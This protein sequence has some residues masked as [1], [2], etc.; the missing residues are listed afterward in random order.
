VVA[1]PVGR[2][3][4]TVA[5]CY[6]TADRVVTVF[7]L[8]LAMC[9]LSGFLGVAQ[10]SQAGSGGGLLMTGPEPI[11]VEGSTTT[12]AAVRCGGRSSSKSRRPIP[13]G[14]IVIVT[15][16]SGRGRPRS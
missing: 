13:A 3:G 5:G 10:G 2:G 12:L 4:D 15:G 8:T 11:V 16:P 7:L 14:E 1:L 9:A 6:L